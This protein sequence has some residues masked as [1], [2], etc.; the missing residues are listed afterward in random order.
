MQQINIRKADFDSFVA[1]SR[2]FVE[3]VEEAQHDI[4]ELYEDIAPSTI[5][6][7]DYRLVSIV[8]SVA[9][10][11][12]DILQKREKIE[13]YIAQLQQKKRLFDN[14]LYALSH[15]ERTVICNRD[16]TIFTVKPL[17]QKF[18][19]YLQQPHILKQHGELLQRLMQKRK[20]DAAEAENIPHEDNMTA[21]DVETYD[22]QV[23]TLYTEAVASGDNSRLFEGYF[24]QDDTYDVMIQ[25][26]RARA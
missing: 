13:R 17:L 9:D 26:R 4:D 10:T 12:I 20:V 23:E 16:Y 11:A 19:A 7:V 6:V 14:F 18:E 8:A 1:A 5:A 21:L 25:H 15:E 24:D 2:H 22:K 3:L